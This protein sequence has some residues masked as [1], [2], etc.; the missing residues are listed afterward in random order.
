MDVVIV[1]AAVWV[2]VE[3]IGAVSAARKAPPV[4]WGD[5]GHGETLSLLKI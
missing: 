5:E 1:V 2:I 3:V 4:E